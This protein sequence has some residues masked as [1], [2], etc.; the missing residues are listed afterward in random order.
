MLAYVLW[1]ASFGRFLHPPK[2][3]QSAVSRIKRAMSVML[4]SR[5]M[6]GWLVLGS[7][8]GL[9][10]CGLVYLALISSFATGSSSGG[11]FYMFVFGMGTLPAMMAVGFF[12]NWFT[13]AIRTKFHKI[14]PVFIAFAGIWL[15]FR[16][17]LIQYPKGDHSPT[18]QITICHGK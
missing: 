12:K 6:H 8:N 5:K 10:P 4:R 17:V 18:D 16:G 3:W 7:L 14:T 9:L 2:F 11:A 13:P 15:L 1:P